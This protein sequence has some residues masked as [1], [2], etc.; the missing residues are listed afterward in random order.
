MYIIFQYTSLI[1]K[2]SLKVFQFLFTNWLLK[3]QY[4]LYGTA[5]LNVNSLN[6]NSFSSIFPK[7][8]KCKYRN[9][10]PS[11]GSQSY[12]FLCILPLNILNE[13]LYLILWFWMF[14]LVVVSFIMIT[15]RLLV[16]F[17]PKLRTYVL[18]VQIRNY[19]MR[20]LEKMVNSMNYGGFFVLHMIG[21]NCHPFV[22]KELLTALYERIKF[23]HNYINDAISNNNDVIIV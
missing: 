14:F 2:F 20:H 13:K 19:D 1:C 21:K 11:G 7:T 9:F 22:L 16:V 18:F 15:Y 6:E 23:P 10:G 4:L 8:T 5:F 17:C 3:G 12:D